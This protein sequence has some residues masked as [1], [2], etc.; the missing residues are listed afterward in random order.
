MSVCIQLLKLA[1]SEIL[2][3]FKIAG[4]QNT[5]RFKERKTLLDVKISCRFGREY[6]QLYPIRFTVSSGN[7]L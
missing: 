5:R 1:N 2:R 6:P 7:W 4:C 3:A